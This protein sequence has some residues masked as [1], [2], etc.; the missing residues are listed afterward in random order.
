ML[1]KRFLALLDC[2]TTETRLI[3]VVM[4]NLNKARIVHREADL[5]QGCAVW[6]L[7]PYW[8]WV[9]W[10]YPPYWWVLTLENPF[11]QVRFSP[12]FVILAAQGSYYPSCEPDASFLIVQAES[13]QAAEYPLLQA[14]DRLR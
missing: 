12:F 1:I 14:V 7:S 2:G 13:P 9:S 8:I 11:G 3:L 4:F 10:G 6:P 5:D